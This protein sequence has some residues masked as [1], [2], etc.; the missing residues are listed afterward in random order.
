MRKMTRSIKEK[1][2]KTR[3]LFISIF[4][5]FR[6]SEFPMFFNMNSARILVR[7]TASKS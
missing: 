4:S 7:L 2:G 3:P 6:M 5:V 1:Y